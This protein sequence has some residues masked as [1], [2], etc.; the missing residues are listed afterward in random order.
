MHPEEYP[1][2]KDFEWISYKP[3]YSTTCLY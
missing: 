1:P 2:P 3:L